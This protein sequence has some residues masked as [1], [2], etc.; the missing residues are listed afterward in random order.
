MDKIKLAF[1]DDQRLFRAGFSRILKS[2][3]NVDLVIVAESGKDLLEQIKVKGEPDIVLI[4]L[5]MPDL[6]GTEVA[7]II[8]EIYP[9]LKTIILTGHDEDELIVRLLQDGFMAYLHKDAQEDEVERA[10]NE[11]FKHG[12]YSSIKA[13]QAMQN[14]HITEQILKKSN[15]HSEP[16]TN[17]E[18]KIITLICKG[19]KDAQIAD[20]L[21]KGL[22]TIQNQK[23]I[24]RKKINAKSTSDIIKYAIQ[25]KLIEENEFSKIRIVKKKF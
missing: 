3:T 19:L 13:L 21:N 14:W 25:H 20:K 7:K 12:S 5:E 10:I 2:F 1:V 18:I 24:L 9:R 4:D 16:L 6:D 11:V 8:R 22:R 15:I 17:S 23:L